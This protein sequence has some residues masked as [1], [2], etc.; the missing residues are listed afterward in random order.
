[1]SFAMRPANASA[2][3]AAAAMG[4]PPGVAPPLPPPTSAGTVSVP[5]SVNQVDAPIHW[6]ADCLKML[7]TWTEKMRNVVYHNVASWMRMK[8]KSEVSVAEVEEMIGIVLRGNADLDAASDHPITWDVEC[9]KV[10]DDG[11]KMMHN[12]IFMMVSEWM[13]SLGRDR[14]T[15]AEVET[16]AW[17]ILNVQS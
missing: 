2:V 14:V 11:A 1:M 6:D 7:D 8:G 13:H 16:V 5:I 12:M 4:P 9:A 10:L 17:N 3:A 15:P